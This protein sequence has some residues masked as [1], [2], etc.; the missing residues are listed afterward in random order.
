[1]NETKVETNF[2]VWWK[3]SNSVMS[4][5]K[6]P[7]DTCSYWTTVFNRS[8]A[9]FYL[10]LLVVYLCVLFDQKIPLFNDTTWDKIPT[11]CYKQR[12]PAPWKIHAKWI[13]CLWDTSPELSQSTVS[14]C[15]LPR[16]FETSSLF[17]RTPFNSIPLFQLIRA[18]VCKVFLWA[19]SL[20]TRAFSD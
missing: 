10:G 5:A 16:P 14:H 3:P 1:M 4:H 17:F 8:G 11:N 6:F 19:V 15:L 13:P 20:T 9:L 2:G 18:V 7:I 12:H